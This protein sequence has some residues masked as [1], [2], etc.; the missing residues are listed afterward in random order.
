MPPTDDH[1]QRF[2]DLLG[3]SMTDE[4]K[5]FAETL[6]KLYQTIPVP[7]NVVQFR[8]SSLISTQEFSPMRSSQSP[9][10]Q[11]I[12]GAPPLLKSKRNTQRGLWSFS[13]IV[14][15]V[16]IVASIFFFASRS[17]SPGNRSLPTM[18]PLNH[19]VMCVEFL[20][21]NFDP[22]SLTQKACEATSATQFRADSP[23]FILA[24]LEPH[25][26]DNYQGTIFIKVS[27]PTPGSETGGTIRVL[28]PSQQSCYG[29]NLASPSAG[30]STPGPT[31]EKGRYAVEV[32][33]TTKLLDPK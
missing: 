32:F 5:D 12:S 33:W 21:G 26:P 1:L 16:V 8:P 9:K 25:L 24:C 14:G 20:P 10:H 6:K 2:A 11:E 15:A 19:V 7:S 29:L 27:N 31:T 28:H 13:L 18:P 22:A 4:L 3:E 17:P 30:V 23:L